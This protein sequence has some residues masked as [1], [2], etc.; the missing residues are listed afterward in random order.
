MNQTLETI[1]S[2]RSIHGNFSNREV[3]QDDLKAITDACVRAANASARQS[4]SV[5]VINDRQTIKEQFCYGGSKALLFCVDFNR[6]IL[7]A[8]YLDHPFST[9]GLVGFITGST[10]T[11][12]AA[13]TAAL[14]AKSMGI[15][16]LF[17]NSIHRCDIAKLKN[18]FGLPK[19]YCFPLIA[20]ILG[21]SQTEPGSRKGRL[22]G[23]GVLHDGKYHK[24]GE[25]ELKELVL[26][27]DDPQKHMGMIDNWRDKG[28]EHYLD[29]FY[30]KWCSPVSAEKGA[31]VY[32]ILEQ[33][34]FIG[35][36]DG[37]PKSSI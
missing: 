13:Q 22:N 2:L 3:S 32:S 18:A 16:S 8:D 15:D 12:M 14:A 11:I 24:P 21:Y 26:T 9:D 20:L 28:Y 19:K 25:E 33:A 31:E 36:P 5:I 4:Y 37:H 34:G 1:Y 27:Y 7:T 17:T 23:T 35:F 6:I 10:D 30:K 29:W